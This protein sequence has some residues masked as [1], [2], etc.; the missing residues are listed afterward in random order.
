MAQQ[1]YTLGPRGKVHFRPLRQSRG[2][3]T[4]TLRGLL[5]LHRQH[6]RV[7]SPNNRSR[8]KRLDHLQPSDSKA[9]LREKDD[10]AVPSRSEPY[11]ARMTTDNISPVENVALF[12]F[13]CRLHPCH[14]QGRSVGFVRPKRALS[15]AIKGGS[16]ATCRVPRTLPTRRAT[17]GIGRET[18]FAVEVSG[19]GIRP[20]VEDT[21][22]HR[23]TFRA[24]WWLDMHS[25]KART[26][27]VR[28]RRHST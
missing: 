28:R 2:P 27:A 19:G 23:W 14:A 12:F 6:A 13:G 21:D 4:N 20:L 16:Q 7:A 9:H 22:L 15:G 1:N 5:S 17:F 11:R 25:P 24:M 26:L 3:A 10:S 18:G 8:K